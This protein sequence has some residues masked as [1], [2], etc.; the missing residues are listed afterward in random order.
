MPSP[1][2]KKKTYKGMFTFQEAVT[3]VL[4]GHALTRAEWKNPMEYILLKDGFLCIHHSADPK[5]RTYRLMVSEGD[6]VGT[7]W[8]II[9]ETEYVKN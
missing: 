3:H 5:E 7:D 1:A 6:M 9:E 8:M 2:L 4:L